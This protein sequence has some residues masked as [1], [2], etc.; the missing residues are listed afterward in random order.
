MA[1]S[2][3]IWQQR[4][5]EKERKRKKRSEGGGGGGEGGGE[6]RGTIIK[7]LRPEQLISKYFVVHI[8]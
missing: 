7:G 1:A 2:T 4:K 6:E 3:N 8:C 5:K